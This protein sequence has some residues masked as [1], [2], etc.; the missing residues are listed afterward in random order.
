MFLLSLLVDGF[1]PAMNE[2]TKRVCFQAKHLGYDVDDLVV[3]TYRNDNED[4][5]LCQMKHSIS[6]SEKDDVFQ[7]VISAAW[8]DFNRK[9][10][11]KENDKVALVT[12][13]IACKSQKALRFLHAQAISSID[14]KQF[15]DRVNLANFSNNDNVRILNI[16]KFCIT[17]TNNEEPTS[18]QLWQF[19][20]CFILLLFDLDCVESVNRALSAS[21]IKC[22]STIDA[23]LVWAR[24]V[25]YASVC[26]QNAA[27]VDKKNIDRSILSFF[28]IKKIYRFHHVR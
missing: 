2:Q 13:Q 26:Y 12:A 24:L 14:E 21:L 20:K 5:M 16:I 7:E 8:N 3:F 1:C 17:K 25:E 27:S 6:I 22:N 23:I 9:D 19:C 4:K 11:D 28:Q 15:M 10:F 18:L